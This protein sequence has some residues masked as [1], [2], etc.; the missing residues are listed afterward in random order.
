[1]NDTIDTIDTIDTSVIA[2]FG[3]IALTNADDPLPH[4][5]ACLRELVRV[6]AILIGE[7]AG[8]RHDVLNIVAAA[9]T[10]A[11]PVS[12]RKRAWRSGHGQ[13]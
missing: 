8:A 6:D 2:E 10:E 4:L 1:M 7:I 9:V 5:A 13:P 3:R 11:L 12:P